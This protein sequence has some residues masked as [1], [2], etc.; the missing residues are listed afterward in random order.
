MRKL[1]NYF[2][3]ICQMNFSLGVSFVLVYIL[4]VLNVLDLADD[5]QCCRDHLSL[6]FL[7]FD[8]SNGNRL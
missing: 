4:S 2:F 7:H 6:R 5:S 8:V 1:D 3:Y